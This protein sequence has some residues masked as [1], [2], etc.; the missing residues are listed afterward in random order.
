MSDY[1]Y[2]AA[3]ADEDV[4]YCKVDELFIL[5]GVSVHVSE[6]SV[7]GMSQGMPSGQH[8][9][10]QP[11]LARLVAQVISSRLLLCSQLQEGQ[12]ACQEVNS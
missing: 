1:T 2:P 7:K 4:S 11:R 5:S 10:L 8:C 9:S 6:E 3:R 12:M